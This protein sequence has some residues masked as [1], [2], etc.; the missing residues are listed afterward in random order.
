MPGAGRRP[1]DRDRPRAPRGGR[2]QDDPRRRGGRADPRRGVL[3]RRLQPRRHAARRDRRRARRPLG[4]GGA[5]LPPAAPPDGRRARH[6]RRGDGEGVA[7]LRRQ[8]LGA[9]GRGGGLPH[10]DGAQE[11]ELLQVRRGRDRGRGRAPDR[12][13]RVRRRGRAGDA[14]LRPAEGD[15]HAAPLEGGGAR[16]PLLPRARPRR[17]RAADGDGRARPRRDRRAPGRADPPPR[18]GG[19]AST[20][21]TVSSRAAGTSCTRAC[22]AT[23]GA[24]S[25]TC[26]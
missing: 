10:E 24:R 19:R 8:R 14:P 26:S 16:L 20:S 21:P 13:L 18:G 1:R 17:G 11:H 5:A 25:P 6:L 12:G 23:T 2:G 4:R 22:P 7:P 15:D 9:G 3:A